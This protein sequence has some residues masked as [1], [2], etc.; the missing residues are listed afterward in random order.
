MFSSR[1][2]AKR[3][4]ANMSEEEKETKRQ[5]AR[6]WYHRNKDKVIRKISVVKRALKKKHL[7]DKLVMGDI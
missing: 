3:R 1:N 7:K 2:S 5:K 6:E 4:Y